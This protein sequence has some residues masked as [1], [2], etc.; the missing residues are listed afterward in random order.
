MPSWPSG[1]LDRRRKL[2]LAAA[3]PGREPPAFD[4]DRIADEPLEAR[5]HV[6]HAAGAA[7]QRHRLPHRREGVGEAARRFQAEAQRDRA[8]GAQ[9]RGERVDEGDLAARIGA[10]VQPPDDRDREGELRRLRQDDPRKGREAG[11]H[12]E[13]LLERVA[14]QRFRREA[15][16]LGERAA[17]AARE[18]GDAARAVRVEL[19]RAP[20]PEEV[21]VQ[22]GEAGRAHGREGLEPVGGMRGRALGA[23][24][25][26]QLVQRARPQ[27]GEGRGLE[28]PLHHLPGRLGANCVHRGIHARPEKASAGRCA[29]PDRPQASLR[30]AFYLMTHAGSTGAGF[31]AIRPARRTACASAPSG[32][33]ATPGWPTVVF[34]GFLEHGFGCAHAGRRVRLRSGDMGHD[35]SPSL[36]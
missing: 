14:R 30:M 20:A 1:A 12:E 4:E 8:R 36:H 18:E 2:R 31:R 29:A 7:D 3:A 25:L 33:R 15:V 24:G 10:L 5:I 6:D 28:E 32:S 26:R 19:R 16:L 23:A 35:G 13:V 9:M 17:P 22:L 21:L 27:L 11:A 34:N